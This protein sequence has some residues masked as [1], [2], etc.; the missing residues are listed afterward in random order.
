MCGRLWRAALMGKAVR[1]ARAVRRFGMFVLAMCFIGAGPAAAQAQ[2]D[3]T[4]QLETQASELHRTGK[5]DE[6]LAVAERLAQLLERKQAA[7]G[8][9]AIA[10]ANL[11][12]YALFAKHPETALAASERALSLAPDAWLAQLN[13]AHALLFL[14]RVDEA[15]AVYLGHKGEFIDGSRKWE[16]TVVEDFHEFRSRGLDHPQITSI[17]EAL[18]QAPE[19]RLAKISAEIDALDDQVIQ[20]E[21]EGKNAEATPLAERVLAA[22]DRELGPLHRDTLQ[23]VI[24]LGTLYRV[25]RRYGEAV[26]LYRRSLEI[27]ARRFGPDDQDTLLNVFNLAWLN[28]ELGRYGEAEPLYER[29]LAGYERTLGADHPSTFMALHNLAHVYQAQG[30][31]N[32]AEP[33]FQRVLAGYER[34]LGSEHGDTL[35]SVSS[36]AELYKM[37]GRYDEA[38]PLYQRALAGRQRALGAE[39]PDTLTAVNNLASL[40]MAEGRYGDAEPLYKRALAGSE[41]ALGPDDPKT[42]TS[43]NNLAVLYDLQGRYSEAEPLYRRALAGREG[44]LGAEHPTT[45]LSVNNMA[46][47]Y[48]AQGRYS[49]AEPLIQ[50]ALA[51]YERSLGIE[52]PS[53]LTTINNLAQL[54]QEQ[55]RYSEAEALH[56]RALASYERTLGADHPLTL[57]SVNNLAIMYQDQGRYSEAEPLLMRALAGRQRALGAERPETLASIASL[58]AAHQAQGRY[59][60]AEPLLLRAL[61][62]YERTLGAE[63]HDTLVSIDLLGNLYKAQGRYGEAEALYKR[64][65]TGSE[66]ALGADHPNTIL[67]ASNLAALYFQQR[68]WPRA[69]QFWRRSTSAIAMRTERRA[70]DTGRAVT[71]KNRSEAEQLSWQFWGLVKA[72]YRLAP[73]GGAPD[74]TS[75]REMFQTA[76]WALSSE[77]AQSLAQMAA[78][79]AKGDGAL[80]RLV[81]ERQDLIAEW[82]KRDALRNAA[83]GRET[84]KRD[85][86]AEAENSVRIA[87]IDMRI[88]SIDE[89]L[90]AEF[91]NYAALA[92]PAPLS[93][94]EVQSQL[95]ADEALALFLDT[96]AWEPTPGETFIWVVT[97]TDM[98]WVRSDLGSEA[99]TNEVRALRC[100][101]DAEA[102]SGDL[103]RTLAGAAYSEADAN[104]GKPLPFDHARAHKLYK[105]LFGP[106][107][108]RRSHQG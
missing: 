37:Q 92:R 77:A 65:L 23:S 57:M 24:R 46:S 72:A 62:G 58:G 51:G 25:Q 22:R 6:A 16:T 35:T 60:E 100:G 14:G 89:H 64:A 59:G 41:R 56:K 39:H 75:S 74:A 101:L 82:Q 52:H 10:R 84:T 80:A 54:Y 102:R 81:R 30:R 20:L 63:H 103:C 45:L 3:D 33:L 12:W 18:A 68:D 105:E 97:K 87:A 38:E 69:V 90:A 83:L 13:R 15:R 99:L 9:T 88:A 61:S 32:E 42:L 29:A 85:A 21:I 28:Q 106:V 107:P 108:G 67:S 36:L 53:T 95:G 91:P 26:P 48:H 34:V 1:V 78:R 17:E 8:V 98:R 27:N 79:S 47:L 19:S 94:E 43:V 66:R 44:A 2:A 73:E 31:Y 104:E 96:A 86:K 71:G 49:E 93:V 11:S 55:Q 70:Q 4:A 5:S 50:R 7:P 76:Q 40:Y